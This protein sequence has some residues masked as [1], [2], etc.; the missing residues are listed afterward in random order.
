MF[1]P[2][3]AQRMR[4][5]LRSEWN[6]DLF[7]YSDTD[8]TNA[9]VGYALYQHRTD[10][11]FPERRVVYLRQFLIERKYRARGL[12][13]RALHELIATRFPPR[14]TVVVDVL[15]AN[16]RGLHFWQQVGFQ[17]YQMTLHASIGGG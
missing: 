12:G 14:C 13:R 16:A 1:V 2:E 17:P 8:V 10:E 4:G 5:W 7:L 6:A 9:V 11:F 15:T 3:L